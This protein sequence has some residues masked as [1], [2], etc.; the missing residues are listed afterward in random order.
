MPLQF[1]EVV[2]FNPMGSYGLGIMKP[3][4][5]GKDKLRE[6]EKHGQYHKPSGGTRRFLPSEDIPAESKLLVGRGVQEEIWTADCGTPFLHCPDARSFHPPTHPSLT[7]FLGH[8][9]AIQ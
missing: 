4:Y 5:R 2:L 8:L 3:F 9:P 7:L 6:G 1:M